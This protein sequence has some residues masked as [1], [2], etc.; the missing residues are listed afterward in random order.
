MFK[1]APW[2]PYRDMDKISTLMGVGSNDA[3]DLLGAILDKISTPE[4]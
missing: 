3:G 4:G 1:M 2:G